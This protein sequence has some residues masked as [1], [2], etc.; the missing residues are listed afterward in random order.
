MEIRP[1]REKRDKEKEEKVKLENS[2]E[3]KNGRIKKTM[4]VRKVKLGK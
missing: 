4:K 1:C 3:R 2:K